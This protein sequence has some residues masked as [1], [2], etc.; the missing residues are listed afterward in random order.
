M[1]GNFPNNPKE[2]YSTT[3]VYT[4]KVTVEPP[5]E[6]KKEMT[7][8]NPSQALPSSPVTVDDLAALEGERS[9]K[10]SKLAFRLSEVFE[11]LQSA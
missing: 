4:P 5:L 1:N 11:V 7:K 8:F 10:L 6:P 2:N 3:N 9:T